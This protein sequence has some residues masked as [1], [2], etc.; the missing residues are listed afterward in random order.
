MSGMTLGLPDADATGVGPGDAHAATA[1]AAATTASEP[2]RAARDRERRP[3]GHGPNC[4]RGPGIPPGTAP[5]RMSAAFA[6]RPT[7]RSCPRS[8]PLRDP[9]PEARR[10]HR[11]HDGAARHDRR[12]RP[13]HRV[14]HGLPRLAAV[15]RPGD[16][17]ARRQQGVDR[18]APPHGRSRDRLRDPRPRAA[19]VA[20]LPRPT[21]DP[22]AVDRRR[23]AGRLPGLARPRDGPAQQLGRVGD[24]APRRGDGAARPAGVRAGPQLLSRPD[25]R[26]RDE[27]A[28]HAPR[29]VHGGRDLRA[30]AVRLPRHRD[31]PVVRVPGLAADE[32]GGR[33]RRSRTPTAPT[34]STAGWRWWSG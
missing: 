31:R 4:S 10:G 28:V 12:R 14:R 21:V 3:G 19:G 17:A 9:V 34:S 27:P 1:S 32:R 33:S 23:R 8:N 26:P 2:L 15:P 29:H 7:T 5:R 24:G 25:R 20:R 30:A 18:V 22:V 11:R 13:G 16:P 6:A